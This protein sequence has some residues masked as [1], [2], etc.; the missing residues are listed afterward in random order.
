MTTIASFSQL[1]LLTP[2]KRWR[3]PTELPNLTGARRIAIDVETNDPTLAELGPGVRRGGYV[4]G[5]A[6]GVEGGGRWYL[7]VRHAGGSNLDEKL[8]WRWARAELNAFTGDVVGANLIYDL[9]Y[10]AESGVTFPRARRFLDVQVAEPLLDENKLGSY[11]LD[12]LT[13]E[14]L[15]EHKVETELR[16]AAAAYGFGA[17]PT[18]IKQN[19]WRLPA[20]YVGAYGEGDVDLPLRILRLQEER[21]AKEDLTELFDLESRLIPLLLAMRRRGVR[22]DVARAEKVRE[23]LSLERDAALK[24]VR[25]IAGPQAELMA[26]ESFSRALQE[27]GMNFPLTGKTRKPS[28]TKGWLKENENDELVALILRGRRVDTIINTFIMGHVF[29]HA[30]R[31][32]IHCEFHQLKGD[33]GGTIARLSSSNPNLQNLPARDD[34]LGPLI[35]SLFVPEE[36]EE[37]GRCDESQIEFRLLTH[38]AVGARAEEARDLY[39]NDPSTDFHNMCAAMLDFDPKSKGQRTRVKNTSF[40]RVYGG[41]IPKIAQTFGC[42]IEEAATFV[43]KYDEAL[44]FI[45]K[46]SD[47]A[48]KRAG[49]RGYVTTVL[50]RRQRFP[51]WEPPNNYSREHRPLPREEALKEYGPNIM[52]AFTYAAL[53]RVLQ[54]SAADLM[55]K[56]MVDVWES[57]ICDVLGAPLVTVHDELGA[58]IP[59]TPAG[60]AAILELKRLM[61]VAVPLRVPVIAE[62][63]R[64]PSWGECK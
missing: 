13:V 8:V 5:L 9:D 61:E 39:R 42:S 6:V 58:S 31:G 46:T 53:N 62:L 60:N 15:G 45:K 56:A 16:E 51:L 63:E 14:Y 28:I 37:W 21:L 19:L 49:A 12:A 29:T 55:K 20:E 64:G 18:E 17:T 10:L 23:R 40:C 54:G 26:P 34:E 7:P 35:R 1:P 11:N 33:E 30:V 27:R 43:K 25:R 59:P 44:P 3:P 32:R 52:R 4:A 41:G 38:F 47:L 24:E 22:V 57:G 36:G 48:T 2:E 50:K